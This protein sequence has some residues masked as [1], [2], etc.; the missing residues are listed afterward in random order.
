MAVDKENKY[1]DTLE[2]V[3]RTSGA[4]WVLVGPDES[5]G[6][7]DP[8]DTAKDEV[9]GL[10]GSKEWEQAKENASDSVISE[11][12]KLLREG[13][14]HEALKFAQ[15]SRE[16][17]KKA[18][19]DTIQKRFSLD[20]LEGAWIFKSC[21]IG[22][23]KVA[24]L[25]KETEGIKAPIKC[26]YMNMDPSQI[27]VRVELIHRHDANPET[28]ISQQIG[29]V[30]F[31]DRDKAGPILVWCDKNGAYWCIDGHHRRL[32][33]INA[34]HIV[35]S[36]IIEGQLYTVSREVP[37]I[38]FFESEGWSIMQAR[39]LG[40]AA[41]LGGGL[42]IEFEDDL[43]DAGA[44]R[45]LTPEEAEK[46]GAK[47]AIDED[48][49]YW[50]GYG[51]D[52]LV[53]DSE[54]LYKVLSVDSKAKTMRVRQAASRA[55]SLNAN[56]RVYPKAVLEEAAARVD[57]LA[58]QH[59]VSSE[60][61]HPALVSDC[62][63]GVCQER[64]VDNPDRKTALV[65]S[66]DHSVSA[67]GWLWI[68]REIKDTTYGRKV[69]KAIDEEK[70][71]GLSTR[72]FMSGR[73]KDW[74]GQKVIVVDHMDIITFDDVSNP[75]VKGAGS[76]VPVTDEAMDFF[77]G[78]AT[79]ST[80]KGAADLGVNGYLGDPFAGVNNST[81][82]PPS[83][84]PEPEIE[85]A[86][87]TDD[88]RREQATEDNTMRLIDI[89]R[90]IGDFNAKYSKP[91]QPQAEYDAEGG[92]IAQMICATKRKGTCV[93]DAAKAF[94]SAVDNA[95][96][97]GYKG[98]SIGI[99]LGAELGGEAGEGWG[100]EIETGEGISRLIM[101]GR[102][103]TAEPHGTG[104]EKGGP[105]KVRG[106][107]NNPTNTPQRDPQVQA[108]LDQHQVMA[109]AQA[110]KDEKRAAKLELQKALDEDEEMKKEPE[111]TKEEV[112]K[113]VKDSV[114][115]RAGV[116]YKA[117]VASQMALVLSTRAKAQRDAKGLGKGSRG[118]T[119][120]DPAN[121][122]QDGNRNPVT[123]T[124]YGQ[125]G[126][127]AAVSDMVPRCTEIFED[128]PYSPMIDKMLAM[129]DDKCRELRGA[130]GDMFADPDSQS[131]QALRRINRMAL[132]PVIDDYTHKAIQTR[133]SVDS[134]RA[135]MDADE[136]CDAAFLNVTAP[137]RAAIDSN[138]EMAAMDATTLS[139]IFTQPYI[140]PVYILQAFQ[141]ITAPQFVGA[142]GPRE[143]NNTSGGFMDKNA[144]Y[145]ASLRIPTYAFNDGAGWNFQDARIDLG[146]LVPEGQG[147]QPSNTTVYWLNYGIQRRRLS[148]ILTW[149]AIKAIGN[150]PGNLPLVSLELYMI[151][152]KEGR[153]IDRA[154]YNEI[155][156]ASRNFGSVAVAS[157]VYSTGSYLPN[158]A[159]YNAA[160]GLTVN[161]NPAKTA[162][163]TPTSTDMRV[164]Y[165]ASVPTGQ[166]PVIGACRLLAG[167][168]NTSS[169]Y[170]GFRGISVIGP[171]PICRPNTQTASGINGQPTS[172]TTNPITVT[173]GSTGQTLGYVTAAGGIGSYPNGP[174]AAVAIDYEMGLI[175]FASGVTG[176]GSPAYIATTFTV[177][178]SFST[179]WD[180]F[181]ADKAISL[182]LGLWGTGGNLTYEQ[183]LNGLMTQV[184]S[185]AAFMGSA[186]NYVKPD[187]ALM[188]LI[189]S[190]Y[191]TP[192]Q[193][194]APL[195]AP[196]GTALYPSPTQFAERNGVMFHRHN[197]PWQAMSQ[198]LMLTRK[199]ATRYCVDT[200]FMLQGPVTVQDQNGNPTGELG[201]YGQEFS[202]L[203]TPMPNDINGNIL[204]CPS[205]EILLRLL[206]QK[207]GVF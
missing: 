196:P 155:I 197:S 157:E 141:D 30:E 161:L 79:D 129:A 77:T 85:G 3:P 108:M 1:P 80:S 61:E 9:V 193:L 84:T 130:N 76:F 138:R 96:M 23:F 97:A 27:G 106:V 171:G 175:L 78:F 19:G 40:E 110:K 112:K 63:N 75:A 28:G 183:Y 121:P 140:L 124:H 18:Q 24:S 170:Y 54:R 163:T 151:A 52:S 15:E 21:S 174:T 64:F 184:D 83:L 35:T 71:I 7:K 66:V 204:N 72:F 42:K 11:Y 107:D 136:S 25:D 173:I 178:Y 73:Y 176:T 104:A 81:I 134:F 203:A 34:R 8:Q 60:F 94:I 93:A 16:E 164:I 10:Y 74:E 137:I 169:G 67:G 41:N 168:L 122:V 48:D 153:I 51:I 99:V 131:T 200:P 114:G 111:E 186:T 4:A 53:C 33:A 202:V 89:P 5:N 117:A 14:P 56:R 207:V 65:T 95:T 165:P 127:M 37:V 123:L 189:G 132:K 166:Q 172:V 187:L 119:A 6:E 88:S 109:A 167:G 180:D 98:G 158:N 139:Q 39:K 199:G 181:I 86:V 87:P 32:S 47:D 103:T 82:N 190:S 68:E 152:A 55:D 31:Y 177:S 149:D 46:L 156:D 2:E 154:M 118:T 143:F 70:P 160:G 188:N 62:R 146:G 116:D 206:T 44:S 198:T 125:V 115:L 20:S 128:N 144:G 22:S 17:I 120:N 38:V 113:A 36:A 191:V 102:A 201:F 192:M 26:A 50:A 145:G 12:C 45:I 148:T 13:K 195:F 91:G 142:M 105:G 135:A 179:N 150:G 90:L 59:L 126:S 182:G 92:L 49:S 185:T 29:I 43:V 100:S 194:M 162:V 57:H 58:K 101:V 69:R 147:I 205:R 133:G 159:V